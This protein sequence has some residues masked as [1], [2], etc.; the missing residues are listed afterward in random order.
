MYVDE[1]GAAQPSGSTYTVD[2]LTRCTDAEAQG[3][4]GRKFVRPC[5]KGEGGGEV[6]VA[7]LPLSQVSKFNVKMLLMKVP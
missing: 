5:R 1:D 2:V 4:D 7:T 3:I 6:L